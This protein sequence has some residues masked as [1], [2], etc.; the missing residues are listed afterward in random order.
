MRR[1]P[2]RCAVW[3]RCD[4]IKAA[5][6]SQTTI[7]HED[8]TSVLARSR[9]HVRGVETVS[10]G[11]LGKRSKAQASHRSGAEA[12]AIGARLGSQGDLGVIQEGTESVLQEAR[13]NGATLHVTDDPV[14]TSSVDKVLD[15]YS[16]IRMGARFQKA[17]AFSTKTKVK[18]LYQVNPALL[19]LEGA[20]KKYRKAFEVAMQC[21][22]A[23]RLVASQPWELHMNEVEE[24]CEILGGPVAGRIY[25]DRLD[26]FLE[27]EQVPW[28]TCERIAL[29]RLIEEHVE[30]DPRDAKKALRCATGATVDLSDRNP[31][32]SCAASSEFVPPSFGYAVSPGDPQDNLVKS[33]TFRHL[34]HALTSHELKHQIRMRDPDFRKQHYRQKYAQAEW[35]KRNQQIEETQV[36]RKDMRTHLEQNTKRNDSFVTLPMTLLFVAVFMSCVSEHLRIFTS[37]TVETSLKE[38]IDGRDP[39]TTATHSVQD[40]RTLWTWMRDVGVPGVLEDPI[41]DEQGFTRYRLASR[42]ILV[43]DIEVNIQYLPES[44]RREDNIWLLH[45]KVA[46]QH[47]QKHPAQYLQAALASVEDLRKSPVGSSPLIDEVAFRILTFNEDIGGFAHTAVVTAFDRF[48]HVRV[49]ISSSAIYTSLYDTWI[50]YIIDLAYGVLTAWVSGKE[51]FDL[52]IQSTSGIDGFRKYWNIWN[53]VDWLNISAASLVAFSWWVL[54]NSIKSSNL[55]QLVDDDSMLIKPDLMVLSE[56]NM[57]ELKDDIYFITRI[58]TGLK[59]ISAI[60]YMALVFRFFK[61]FESNMRLQVITDT[62]RNAMTDLV[63]FYIVFSCVFAPFAIVSHILFGHDFEELASMTSAMQN[64]IKLILRDFEWYGDAG[65]VVLNEVLPSGLPQVVLFLWFV[66]F[67]VVMVVIILNM[68]LGIIFEHYTRVA[69]RLS[70]YHDAP[71]LWKQ[72]NR[73]IKFVRETLGFIS[74]DKLLIRL[75]NDQV[76]AEERVSEESLLGSFEGMKSKQAHW[77][78]EFLRQHMFRQHQVQEMWNESLFDER[79]ILE[80]AEAVYEE[81]FELRRQVLDVEVYSAVTSVLDAVVK[82]LRKER[83]DGKALAQHLEVIE[84]YLETHDPPAALIVTP[85]QAAAE[86]QG[87]QQSGRPLKRAQAAKAAT[88]AT[89]VVRLSGAKPPKRELTASAPPK[90]P[91]SA[92]SVSARTWPGGDPEGVRSA[93]VVSGKRRKPTA[94]STTTAPLRPRKAQTAAN[95]TIAGAHQA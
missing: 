27:L 60:A 84:R 21:Q 24:F 8:T 95:A 31:H 58:I 48:G 75:E 94:S 90:A 12:V 3:G 49:V 85:P 83:R 86:Q 14:R 36:L 43:G 37:S 2:S 15:A 4:A 6:M 30:K 73:Y 74:L 32:L 7:G 69:K 17:T 72:V 18:R 47:L 76:H 40:L 1:A 41:L 50:P 42:S 53:L 82:I 91:S 81:V 26:A 89:A 51:A 22:C 55:R 63:H 77:L 93:G 19:N 34:Y 56:H 16:K 35:L 61:A 39:N 71:E 5:A 59:L 62:L 29:H 78:M 38:W 65:P 23:I 80:R 46:K 88:S 13:A 28:S 70:L 57:H 67:Q 20:P 11:N 52:V 68:L 25:I 66:V 64:S 54:W 10:L 92:S 79:L 9:L 33:C 87:G 45:T 44:G